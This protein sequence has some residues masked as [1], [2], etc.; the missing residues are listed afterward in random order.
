MI[1]LYEKRRLNHLQLR[2]LP[3]PLQ[4]GREH[5]HPQIPARRVSCAGQLYKTKE[6]GNSKYKNIQITGPWLF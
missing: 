6:T 4:R 2:D 1:P 5:Q 3:P